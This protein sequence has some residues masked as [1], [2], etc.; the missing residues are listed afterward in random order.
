MSL[1]QEFAFLLASF[2]QR[3]FYCGVG[4]LVLLFVGVPVAILF[5]AYLI[6]IVVM[7]VK[8]LRNNRKE[9]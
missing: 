4:R 3:I 5:T 7:C 6:G 2:F 8:E 9:R 1:L